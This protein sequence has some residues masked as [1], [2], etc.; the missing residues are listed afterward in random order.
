MSDRSAPITEASRARESVRLAALSEGSAERARQKAQALD[1]KAQRQM[2]RKAGGHM[3]RASESW[4]DAVRHFVAAADAA[5]RN[6][7]RAEDVGRLDR[8]AGGASA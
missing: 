4:S 6:A 5:R 2:M 3:M 7:E 1:G 8:E